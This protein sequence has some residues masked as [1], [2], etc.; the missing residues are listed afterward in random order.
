MPHRN[1][2][3]FFFLFDVLELQTALNGKQCKTH[4][5]NAKCTDQ[6]SIKLGCRGHSP[7]LLLPLLRRLLRNRSIEQKR[8]IS[9]LFIASL[10]NCVQNTSHI[11][12]HLFTCFWSISWL[13]LLEQTDTHE[14][15]MSCGS[16]PTIHRTCAEHL[17]RKNVTWYTGDMALDSQSPLLFA[18]LSLNFLYQNS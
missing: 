8:F 6:K 12:T 7:L 3:S 14:L 5:W 15:H 4:L 13:V 10:A 2:S 1:W 11:F 17:P 16:E 18:R 9:E